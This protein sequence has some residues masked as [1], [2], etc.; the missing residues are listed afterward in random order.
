MPSFGA[1][2]PSG[3]GALFA[4]GGTVAGP[5]GT[6]GAMAWW[7]LVVAVMGAVT[8]WAYRT[9]HDRVFRIGCIAL[10]LY[11]I[12]GAVGFAAEYLDCALCR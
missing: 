4:F 8:F 3:R 1:P 5:R 9:R 12:F 6:V 7:F 2:R 10:F 11:V